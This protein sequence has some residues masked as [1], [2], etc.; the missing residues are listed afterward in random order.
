[1]FKPV[2]YSSSEA[3]S[4][5][6]LAVE[7]YSCAVEEEGT[8]VNTPKKLARKLRSSFGKGSGRRLCPLLDGGDPDAFL[9]SNPIPPYES[10]HI[11]TY[12]QYNV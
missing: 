3:Q 2:C 6:E 4:D 9:Q 7:L 11:N 5:F 8:L 10:F 1:M 12:T